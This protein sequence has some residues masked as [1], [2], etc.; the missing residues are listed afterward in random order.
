MTAYLNEFL[1][2]NK[3][4]Q[5]KNTFWLPTCEKFERL[6]DHAP[7]E[8]RILRKKFELNDNENFNLQEQRNLK[9]SSQ[10]L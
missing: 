1:R 4:E 5:Q 2:R 3:P 7:I 6:E 9:K 8:M 10:T